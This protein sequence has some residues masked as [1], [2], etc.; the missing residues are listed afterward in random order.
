MS[1]TDEDVIDA[2][3]VLGEKLT[4]SEATEVEFET[5]LQQCNEAISEEIGIQY[6]EACDAGGSC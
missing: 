1:P 2:A 3:E 5:I 4:Q 6:G